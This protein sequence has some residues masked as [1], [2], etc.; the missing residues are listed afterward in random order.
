[1]GK[2]FPERRNGQTENKGEIVRGVFSVARVVVLKEWPGVPEGKT[3]FITMLQI[4]EKRKNQKQPCSLLTLFQ[5]LRYLL[6]FFSRTV[7]LR[8]NLH[9]IN[10]PV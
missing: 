3:V 8:E 1:M 9:I 4:G 6:H 7:V 2:N 5:V 10:P